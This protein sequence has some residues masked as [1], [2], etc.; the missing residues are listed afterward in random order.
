MLPSATVRLMALKSRS[1]RK[2]K[3]YTVRF[4]G[5]AADMVRRQV[6]TAG[7]AGNEYMRRLCLRYGP[8]LVRE[9]AS[10]QEAAS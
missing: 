6:S 5:A 1:P 3:E 2:E 9:L 8:K 4:R 7:L 10:T